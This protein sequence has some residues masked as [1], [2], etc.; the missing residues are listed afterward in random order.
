MA[1]ASSLP[2]IVPGPP[3]DYT[4]GHSVG[5]ELLNR[6]FVYGSCQEMCPLSEIEMREHENLIHILETDPSLYQEKKWREKL[7]CDRARAV[8]CYHR[9]AA[10]MDMQNPHLLRPPHVL[11]Q[12]VTYLLTQ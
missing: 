4:D 8:K 5:N 11:R 12:T 2:K 1:I 6:P 3:P 7:I 9:S 10:G